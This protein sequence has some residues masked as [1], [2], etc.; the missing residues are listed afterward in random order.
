MRG[1]VVRGLPLLLGLPSLLAFQHVLVELPKERLVLVGL[2][3]RN[4]LPPRFPEETIRERLLLNLG[5]IARLP[6]LAERVQLVRRS[7]ELTEMTLTENPRLSR[8]TT[9]TGIG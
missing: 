6:L 5:R 2:R 1:S 3:L 8:R 4:R 7:F 9:K